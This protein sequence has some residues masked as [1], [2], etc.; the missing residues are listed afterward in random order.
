MFNA[1]AAGN[2]TIN[3]KTHALLYFE[4]IIVN[5][6]VSNRLINSAFTNLLVQM[7]KQIKTPQIRIRLCSVI[8]LLIRH[9][10]VIDNE[11]AES[12]L[13]PQLIE[14]M[15]DRN[16]K[17]RKKAIAA[18]GEYMF[19]AATQL[20]D[21]QCEQCWEISDDA[22]HVIVRS[23]NQNEDETVRFYA[24]KTLENITAQSN[25]AGD[26]FATPEAVTS[27]LSL[28]L[29]QPGSINEHMRISAAAALSH[30]CKLQPKLFPQIFI[31]VTP[32]LFFYTLAEG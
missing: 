30:T 27:L 13:C 1:L 6:N 10:T 14:I 3:E 2:S 22:I 24:C 18:L 20:D 15:K 31:K 23:L 25:S 26:R 4:S 16:E 29:A 28:F 19:Y 12:D 11:I 9:S 7:L 8:G 17:V 32:K 5:N 21:E